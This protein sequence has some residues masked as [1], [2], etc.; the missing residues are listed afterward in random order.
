MSM[1]TMQIDAL[2]ILS[3]KLTPHHLVKCGAVPRQ[4]EA[5]YLIGML[6]GAIFNL[7]RLLDKSMADG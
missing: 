2:R 1:L 6:K 4:N 5:E 3:T 7:E